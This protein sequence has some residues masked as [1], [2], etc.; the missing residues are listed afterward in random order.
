[1]DFERESKLIDPMVANKPSTTAVLAC[2]I[3]G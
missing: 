3:V 1:V 2:I